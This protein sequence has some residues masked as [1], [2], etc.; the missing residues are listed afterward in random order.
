MLSTNL[1]ELVQEWLDCS[2]TDNS[3]GKLDD[4][5]FSD[6][7]TA[8]SGILAILQHDLSDRQM[9]I[10]AA[11]IVENLLSEHGEQ[12]I[13]RVEAEAVRNSRFQYLLGGVWKCG[14]SDGVWTRV[15]AARKEVWQ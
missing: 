15:R 4:A 1:D 6:P 5:P 7:E 13:E 11:G 10:L 3:W 12:F 9:S 2:Q 8:W 14:M